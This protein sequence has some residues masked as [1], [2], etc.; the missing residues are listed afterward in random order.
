MNPIPCL[1]LKTVNHR[2][3]AE[4]IA[5]FTR[6]LDAGWYI[7][8]QEVAAF[9]T[10]F[11]EWNGSRYCIGVGNGLDALSLV[12][13]AWI[14]TRELAE[15]DE[16]IVPANTYIASILAISAARLIP[17]LVEPD[18][19]T[20]NLDPDRVTA[21]VTP[22]TRAI[23][24]VHL[25]GHAADMT[26]LCALANAHNLKLLED[27][28]Q[29]HGAEHAGRKV[30][31]W[32][33]AA[34]FSF[35]PT[36]NLGALGDAGAVTTD[37][38]ELAVLLRALRNYGSQAKYYNR[39]RGVNSRLD[40]IQAALLRVSLP[41]LNTDNGQRRSIA[42]TYLSTIVHPQVQL[43]VEPA[44]ESAHVWHLF[45]VRCKRRDALQSHLLAH[46]VQTLIHYPIPPYR[47][48][49]YQ[50]T[51]SGAWPITDA[52]HAEVLSLPMGLHLT[53]EDV[54]QIAAA[55]NAFPVSG[56]GA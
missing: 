23:L 11:A 7:L 20:F 12:F 6:V 10:E 18:P 37:N 40:E 48:E 51:A 26:R 46:G 16:V 17:V 14:E 52:I 32:G 8:G 5:A 33:D 56:T 42:R 21:A 1:D 55:I 35:Y 2:H 38:K 15:G 22:R 36:K 13:R 27:C 31:T 25:Y 34:A 39:Y 53:P 45:V 24:A 50:G 54:R 29:A 49:S 9:E 44:D 4:L 28:A 47:Q 3:R 41:Q 30:G 43:P 19:V